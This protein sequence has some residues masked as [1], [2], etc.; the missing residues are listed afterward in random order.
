M[1]QGIGNLSMDP[2][3]IKQREELR[4]KKPKNLDQSL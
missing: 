1:A 4:A 2:E 3:Y